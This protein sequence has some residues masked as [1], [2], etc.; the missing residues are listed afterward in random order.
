MIRQNGETTRLRLVTS[1]PDARALTS[2]GRMGFN[3]L[4]QA[5]FY[6]SGAMENHR[7]TVNWKKSVQVDT[8]YYTVGWI[9]KHFF[10]KCKLLMSQKSPYGTKI[11]YTKFELDL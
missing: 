8:P 10:G 3:F 1:M 7:S 5:V 4:V 2:R 9:E 6:Y 11:L